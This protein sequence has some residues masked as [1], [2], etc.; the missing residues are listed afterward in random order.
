MRNILN[1]KSK[2]IKFHDV[3]QIKPNKDKKS[4]K[5]SI[6]VSTSELIVPKRVYTQVKV[7]HCIN[8]H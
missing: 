1:E 6:S 5:H 8:L 3:D 7:P 4:K 2:P